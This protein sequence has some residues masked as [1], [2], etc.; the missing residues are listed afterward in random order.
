M[1]VSARDRLWRR[2]PRGGAA[3][4]IGL[5]NNMPDAALK[6]TE[7]QWRELLAGAA[8]GFA[9]ELRIFSFPELPRSADGRNYVGAHHE[10]IANLWSSELDGLIVTGAAPVAPRLDDEPCWPALTRLVDW[11]ERHTTSTIWS[12]LAAHA[13]VRYLDGIERRRRPAKLS[14]VF[15][16]DK[17]AE[18]PLLALTPARW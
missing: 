16:C 8:G 12:C 5:V 6:T 15:A 11:A 1:T 17:V 3:L 9:I 14:G 10:P 7:R 4:T 13:A 2:P 18:H